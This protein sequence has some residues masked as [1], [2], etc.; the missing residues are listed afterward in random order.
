[1]TRLAATLLDCRFDDLRQREQERNRRQL[2]RY[3]SA[4]VA[5]TLIFMGISVYAVVE[6]SFADEASLEASSREL[7]ANAAF[8]SKDDP[9]LSLR[10]SIEAWKVA[11]TDQAET[12]FRNAIDRYKKSNFRAAFNHPESVRWA[13][14]NQAGDRIVTA[15]EDGTARLYSIEGGG[16][17]REFRTEAKDSSGYNQIMYQA[18]FSPDGLHVVT[19][20]KDGR[21]RVFAAESGTKEMDEL[22]V[23]PDDKSKALRSA[24][25][26]P[27]GKYVVTAG[28]S[29]TVT[30]WDL[31]GRTSRVLEG[32]KGHQGRVYSA[33]FSADGSLVATASADGTMRILDAAS[34]R[35]IDVL[36]HENQKALRAAVFKPGSNS[37]LLGVGEDSNIWDINRKTVIA[38]LTGNKDLIRWAAFSSDG[39]R[40]ATASNDQKMR[41]YDIEKIESGIGAPKLT[42]E[43]HGGSVN[44]VQFSPY[45]NYVMTSS[46]DNTARLWTLEPEA[47]NIRPAAYKQAVRSVAFSFDGTRLATAS[48]DGTA[49]VWTPGTKPVELR[50]PAAGAWIMGIA[51]AADGRLIATAGADKVARIWNGDT[52][53]MLREFRGHNSI[54]YSIAFSSGATW[55][56]TAGGTAQFGFGM[57]KLVMRS[58]SASTVSRASV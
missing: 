13:A 7:A 11:P 20:S 18:N 21:V 43:T 9:D 49:H 6:R 30:V 12:A 51:F 8:V 58:P 25:F 41:I 40:V 10:L 14:F 33:T 2:K 44:N 4:A 42:F 54:V 27:D 39:K 37:E 19:A 23:K 26:S 3:L 22:A 29:G 34:G 52:G 31:Q 45:G 16:P 24:F 1:M 15:C 46:A 5:S 35:L 28:E 38:S 57:S 17:I 48:E 32:A 36:E 50:S 53:G 56:A 55:L 47:S